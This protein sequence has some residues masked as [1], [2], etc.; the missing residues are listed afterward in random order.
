MR[1]GKR[2]IPRRPG[3]LAFLPVLAAVPNVG[4]ERVRRADGIDIVEAFFPHS[5]SSTVTDPTTDHRRRR[6][7]ASLTSRP[8]GQFGTSTPQRP[9][10]HRQNPQREP[11]L[12]V[13]RSRL[14]QP[15]RQPERYPK[16]RRRRTD[17]SRGNVAKIA[18]EQ[19]INDRGSVTPQR[20]PH[21]VGDAEQETLALPSQLPRQDELISARPNGKL[22]WRRTLR[23]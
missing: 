8:G 13:L 19:P 10:R 23:W 15:L 9:R 18:A 7:G 20:L 12:A 22:P 3:A 6:Q 5:M 16:L 11:R 2:V 21:M 14:R 17:A 1:Q 4:C